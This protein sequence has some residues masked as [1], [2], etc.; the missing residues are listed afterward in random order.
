MQSQKEAL[1]FLECSIKKAYEYE[2]LFSKLKQNDCLELGENL[3][4]NKTHYGDIKKKSENL[5]TLIINSDV[6]DFQPCMND[7]KLISKENLKKIKSNE[8]SYKSFLSNSSE[9]P[10]KVG[11]ENTL[12][13]SSKFTEMKK[14]FDKYLKAKQDLSD[15]N[16][17]NIEF[18]NLDSLFCI[19]KES[20]YR[21]LKSKLNEKEGKIKEL[22]KK[23]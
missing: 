1:N 3:V 13:L 22:E 17:E 12:I 20:A 14:I 2:K 10:V 15:K 23:V 11:E 8:A 21:A 7:N 16:D 19:L 18:K 5:E 4:I 6:E 9:Y